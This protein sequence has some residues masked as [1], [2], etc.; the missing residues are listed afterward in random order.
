[1]DNCVNKGVFRLKEEYVVGENRPVKLRVSD[2][3]TATFEIT[4]ATYQVINR[5]GEIVTQGR[6]EI[7]NGEHTVMFY[8]NPTS[9]GS[10]TLEFEITVPP[11]IRIIDL[12]ANVRKQGEAVN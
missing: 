5:R 12:T 11:T 10:F 6:C 4:E 2:K 8:F 9:P 7:D 1:M 3:L